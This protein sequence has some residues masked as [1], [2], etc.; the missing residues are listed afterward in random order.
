MGIKYYTGN[1]INLT[2]TVKVL[3]HGN[4]TNIVVVGNNSNKSI[5]S[6]LRLLLRNLLM[7][8]IL[9]CDDVEYTIHV[10]NIGDVAANNTYVADSFPEGLEVDPDS[11]SH[12]GYILNGVITWVLNLTAG[13]SV[14]LTYVA[15]VA[16]YGNLTNIVAA[17][18]NSNKTIISVPEII[19]NKFTENSTYY[20]FD[21]VEYTIEVKNIGNVDANNVHIGDSLPEGVE[22]INGTISH[23][24]IY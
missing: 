22:V 8:L 14:D 11:I 19:V 4:L 12:D 15:R 23:V 1:H 24:V 5:I 6:I 3:A 20:Y 10:T 13:E 7:L 2:Y 17:G 21:D 18:N 16:A 9:T